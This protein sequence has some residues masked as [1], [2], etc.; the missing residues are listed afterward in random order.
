MRLREVERGESLASCLLIGFIS[1]ASGMRAAGCRSSGLLP[2]GLR[3]PAR[4]MD[5]SGHAWAEYLDDW[6]ARADGGHGREVE[7]L[8]LL[9]GRTPRDRGKTNCRPLCHPTHWAC[10][11]V[12][13]SETPPPNLRRPRALLLVK[14]ELG[15]T[16]RAVRPALEIPPLMR[17]VGGSERTTVRQFFVGSNEGP[18]WSIGCKLLQKRTLSIYSGGESDSR[19]QFR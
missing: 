1:L 5:A 17:A 13:Y 2:S 8:H 19:G 12:K 6:R 18:S 14:S 15:V 3:Q 9:P 10:E 4:R 11:R 16:L 7:F